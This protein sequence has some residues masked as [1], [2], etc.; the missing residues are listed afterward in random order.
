MTEE[1]GP[2]IPFLSTD[3]TGVW[4]KN[5]FWKRKM[6]ELGAKQTNKKKTQLSHSWRVVSVTK[7]P[8]GVREER[9]E[10]QEKDTDAQRRGELWVLGK[11]KQEV[12]GRHERWGTD[13]HRQTDRQTELKY[14]Q[15]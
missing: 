10:G 12:G 3:L 13:R 15:W 7:P 9:R 1:E 8:V 4:E 6:K 5:S 14:H 11:Q 2:N